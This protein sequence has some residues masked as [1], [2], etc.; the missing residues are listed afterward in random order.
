MW[1]ERLI[2]SFNGEDGYEVDKRVSFDGGDLALNDGGGD[3]SRTQGCFRV[4]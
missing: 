4:P 2:L 1:N 3:R